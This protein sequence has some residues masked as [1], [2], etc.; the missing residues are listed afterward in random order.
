[1][2]MAKESGQSMMDEIWELVHLED[3]DTPA[4]PV[5][6]A[7]R[8]KQPDHRKDC[9]ISALLTDRDT[10]QERNRNLEAI[11]DVMSSDD[12]V[13]IA[14]VLT[15]ATN[16][17]GVNQTFNR[18]PYYLTKLAKNLVGALTDLEDLTK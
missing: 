7:C 16:T 13:F 2:G 18:D 6:K 1:M 9:P 11:A 10:L 4:V 8:K 14:D 12:A 15:T 5:C 3:W 17:H